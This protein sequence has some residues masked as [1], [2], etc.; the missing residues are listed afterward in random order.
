MRP[1]ERVVP[2]V[3][4]LFAAVMFTAP[5]NAQIGPEDKIRDILEKVSEEMAEIDRLL[6]Q[7]S[8]TPAGEGMQRNVDRLKELMEQTRG[9]QGEVVQSIDELIDELQKMSQQSSSGSGQAGE[10]QQGDQQQPPQGAGNP[11]GVRD[12]TQTPDMVNRGEQQGRQP[13]GQQEQGS[14]PQDGQEPF[15][16]GRNRRDGSVAEDGTERIERAADAESW[17]DLPKYV[18]FL[19]TRGGVPEIPEKYRRAYEAYLRRSQKR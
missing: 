5:A 18:P 4:A 13:E 11:Q 15:A 3:L 7:S 10:P 6:L 19:H 9:S 2:I 17:G 16:P 14:M 1:I 12:Q 8:R